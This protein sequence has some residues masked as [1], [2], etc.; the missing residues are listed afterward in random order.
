MIFL[1]SSEAEKEEV[2][3]LA[4]LRQENDH[5][6]ASFYWPE[7]SLKDELSRTRGYAI[8]E[9]PEAP[10]QAFILFRHLGDVAEITCL[11]TA[12]FAQKKGK[13]TELL[14]QVIN[15]EWA[16]AEWWLEVHEFNEPAL[17]LYNKL[18]FV[19]SGRRPRYYK[20][21][22]AA[23]LLKLKLATTEGFC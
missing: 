15:L 7:E 14:T 8:R 1:I 2:I 18:G 17:A 13:M 3:Q 22:G 16:Y 11:A 21:Q 19:A 6:M 5:S 9:N 20:D 12:V 23:I 10:M 4:R